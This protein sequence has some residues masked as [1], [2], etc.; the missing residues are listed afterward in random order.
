MSD[1]IRAHEGNPDFGVTEPNKVHW[2]KFNMLGRFIHTT[3][4]CQLQCQLTPDY[5][6]P[7]RLKIR[8]L[9]FNDFVMSEEVSSYRLC[10]N[11]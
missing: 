9:V 11:P 7:D 6:F 2:G 3:T 5:N 4:Q 10:H 8:D 1:L